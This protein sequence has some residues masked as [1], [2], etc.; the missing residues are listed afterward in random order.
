[1]FCGEL[2]ILNHILKFSINS[3]V[4]KKYQLMLISPRSGVDYND[5]LAA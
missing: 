5:K 2:L 4:L 3:W 1:M